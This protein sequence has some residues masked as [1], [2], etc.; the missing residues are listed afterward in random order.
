M[1]KIPCGMEAAR[2]GELS[3]RVQPQRGCA[4]LSPALPAAILP[5]VRATPRS[6]LPCPHLN[7]PGL[8]ICC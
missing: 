4:A 7:W 3:P 5:C 6:R 8:V 1:Q 2:S